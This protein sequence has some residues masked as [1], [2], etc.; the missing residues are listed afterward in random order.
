MGAMSMLDGELKFQY[1]QPNQIRDFWPL[2]REGMEEVK[3]N[4]KTGWIVEDMYMALVNNHSTLHIGYVGNEYRG[5][6]VLTPTQDYNGTNLHVWATYC[7]KQ[8]F[9]LMS[10]GIVE[11]NELACR[12]QAK[13]ITF[14]SPRKGWE[15]QAQKLDFEPV[16]TRYAR[17]VI[18]DKVQS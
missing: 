12:I 10:S 2:V 17:A 16:S 13:T 14:D 6:M 18:M 1:I 8:G 4:S 5:F 3:A 7:N 11:I 9:D 15:K